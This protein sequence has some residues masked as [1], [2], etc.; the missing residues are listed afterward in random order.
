MKIPDTLK[1]QIDEACEIANK[2]QGHRGLR[3]IFDQV[4]GGIEDHDCVKDVIRMIE[5]STI[6]LGAFNDIRTA[7]DA[8]LEE[9]NELMKEHGLKT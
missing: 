9:L 1:T 6:E 2:H 3:K 7:Q 8:K 4:L 5:N